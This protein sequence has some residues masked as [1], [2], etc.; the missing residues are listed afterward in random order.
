MISHK[1]AACNI[2]EH[3]VELEPL[4]RNFVVQIGAEMTFS[5]LMS[6]SIHSN[7]LVLCK[8]KVLVRKTDKNQEQI[9]KKHFCNNRHEFQ[10]KY[11]W[12]NKRKVKK[13]RRKVTMEK[14]VKIRNSKLHDILNISNIT[15]I[16]RSSRSQIVFNIK[17]S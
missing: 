14:M 7:L 17:C 11:Y 1:I 6:S 8:N 4:E 16:D 3:L 10:L 9:M 12:T 5:I 15:F 13:V 2:V